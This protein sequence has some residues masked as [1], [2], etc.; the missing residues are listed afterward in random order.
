MKNLCLK[1]ILIVDDVAELRAMLSQALKKINVQCV[2]AEN[3]RKALEMLKA[4]KFNLV[5]CDIRMPEMTG[6]QLFSQVL[7]AGI[8]VPFVFMTGDGDEEIILQA[9]RLGCVDYFRKPF[10]INDITVVLTR[11]L[12]LEG[13]KEL[14]DKALAK[15]D[16]QVS[17]YVKHNERVMALLRVANSLKRS[18]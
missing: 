13:R 7:L 14:I 16:P 4:N 10:S 9:M 11:M 1:K 8:S 6:L 12:E 18:Y 3:G 17:K 5:L 15:K 2:E